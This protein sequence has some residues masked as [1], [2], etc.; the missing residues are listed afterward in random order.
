MNSASRGVKSLDSCPMNLIDSK[1][2]FFALS[3]SATCLAS[4]DV[5]SCSCWYSS[6]MLLGHCPLLMLL[7]EDDELSLDEADDAKALSEDSL[8]ASDPLDK[9]I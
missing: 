9:E 6:T 8:D 2:T 3:R 5:I 1:K 7:E 4:S